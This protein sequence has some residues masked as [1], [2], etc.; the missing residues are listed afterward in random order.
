MIM[1]RSLPYF[2]ST[3]I[4]AEYVQES[5]CTIINMHYREVLSVNVEKTIP[6]R[7]GDSVNIK[8]LDSA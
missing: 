7:E 5:I 4:A 3:I 2:A 1:T 6:T 8:R